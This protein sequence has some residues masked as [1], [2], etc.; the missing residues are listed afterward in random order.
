M[1]PGPFNYFVIPARDCNYGAILPLRTELYNLYTNARRAAQFNL[2]DIFAQYPTPPGSVAHSLHDLYISNADRN[3]DFFA[4]V[5]AFKSILN[6]MWDRLELAK[7]FGLERLG[8]IE[9]NW[10]SRLH[11]T[12]SFEIDS[13]AYRGNDVILACQWYAFEMR[14]AGENFKIVWVDYGYADL[15]GSSLN[16]DLKTKYP[17]VDGEI[18]SG[19]AKGDDTPIREKMRTTATARPKNSFLLGDKE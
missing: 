6:P 5:V 10:T 12:N 19:M 7:R 14:E 16:L 18:I 9:E 1:S 2:E 4:R 13:C 15:E 8:A 3:P 11:S 17:L